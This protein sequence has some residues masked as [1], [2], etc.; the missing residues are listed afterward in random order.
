[1]FFT[2]AFYECNL[3]YYYNKDGI[4]FTRRDDLVGIEVSEKKN[5]DDT[6]M[7]YAQVFPFEECLYM[8]Y[9]GNEY[10]REGLG[11]ARIPIENLK[12]W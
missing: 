11:L 2:E 4:H 10:G 6:A 5:W 12:K 1:M 9:N 8:I 7:C 3:R